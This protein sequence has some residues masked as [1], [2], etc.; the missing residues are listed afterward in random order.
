MKTAGPQFRTTIP[1]EIQPR[2]GML[3]RDLRSRWLRTFTNG[4]K[5]RPI[6]RT[7]LRLERLDDR[8]VPAITFDPIS[9]FTFPGGKDLFVPLTAVDSTGVPITYTVQPPTSPITATIVNGGTT[10]KMTVT[11][12]DKDGNTFTGEIAIR[13]FND[14][15]PTAVARITSLVNSG[16]YDGKLFHRVIND[17]MAQ[18]GSVNNDGTGNSGQGT[19][20]DEF[21]SAVT[22][23]S[24]GLIALANSGNDTN[25][26]QFFIVDTDLS[27]AQLPQHLN[28]KHSIV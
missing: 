28:F 3:F 22:F 10:I 11:G 19:F 18:G 8:V 4:R 15:A 20:D 17:F 6:R 24:P 26:T 13:L 25:D 9:N 7:P 2:T 23:V 12:K 14:I 16:F 27:L 21:N 1:L 5:V